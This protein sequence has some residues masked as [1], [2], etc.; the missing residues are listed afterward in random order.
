MTWQE[1]IQTFKTMVTASGS[2]RTARVYAH[3]IVVFH[4][5]VPI[6]SPSEMT[7]DDVDSFLTSMI[8][9]GNSPS[10][11][12]QAFAALRF[13]FEK[14]LL[15]EF[16]PYDRTNRGQT[17][18]APPEV[19]TLE[20]I[21]RVL[22]VLDPPV[23]IMAKLIYG[24]GLRLDECL[25]LR[26]K[27]IDIPNRQVLI[28]TD[29]GF[30]RAIPLP[31]AIIP[32][33]NKQIKRC[34]LLYQNDLE[35]DYAGA[36]MSEAFVKA[37][38]ADPMA[39]EWQY[40]FPAANLTEVKTDLTRRRAH[41]HSTFLQKAMVMAAKDAKLGKKAPPRVL[42]HSCCLHLLADGMDPATVQEI[43][44]H[45]SPR[46]TAIYLQLLKQDSPPK[47]FVSPL[48]RL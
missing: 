13:F 48:D 22:A 28:L 9:K 35:D 45:K 20:E 43:M 36:F 44:G 21:R 8:E 26:L 11:Q 12:R 42:R 10:V 46:I 14:L 31:R 34:H 17:Y 3:W 38:N 27:A 41:L 16:R 19:L 33:L 1:T 5:H 40:L 25:T 24:C 4:R 7:L 6:K 39:E 23:S 18:T 15:K 37:N 29:K 32:L 47:K 30:D 2:S